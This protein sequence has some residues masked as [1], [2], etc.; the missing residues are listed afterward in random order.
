VLNGDGTMGA[1]QTLLVQATSVDET[2]V[3]VT[4]GSHE[5]QVISK[6]T[7][8][9]AWTA[10][11]AQQSL[12]KDFDPALVRLFDGHHQGALMQVQGTDDTPLDVKIDGAATTLPQVTLTNDFG[13]V[14]FAATSGRS[15]VHVA[16]EVATAETAGGQDDQ[17]AVVRLRQNGIDEVSVTLFRVDDLDGSIGGLKPGDALYATAAQIRAYQTTEG[18]SAIFGAGYGDYTQAILT[19]VDAGDLIAI[20]LTNHST[21]HDYWSFAQA[22]EIDGNGDHVGHAWNYGLNTWG[23]EDQLGGG[24]RDF[25]DVIVGLDFTSTAG[26]G[27]TV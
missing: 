24:D 21:G 1:T 3:T 9:F 2:T 19:N 22:N 26:H 18:G 10:R 8:P 20:K 17:L 5:Q 15:T 27:W 13:F 6:A 23:F 4:A 7:A 25:N 12:Q 16:R 11:L 14:D